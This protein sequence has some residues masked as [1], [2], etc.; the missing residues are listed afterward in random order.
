M[1]RGQYDRAAA[2]AKREAAEGKPAPKAAKAEKTAAAADA[3]VKRKYTR[4]AVVAGQ[5]VAAG[6]GPRIPR[7]APLV[8]GRLD[9]EVGDL[10]RLERL[11]NIRTQFGSGHSGGGAV[12]NKL[13]ALIGVEADKLMPADTKVAEVKAEKEPKTAKNG[14]IKA[15]APVDPATLPGFNP[16]PPP[17]LQQ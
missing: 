2:K 14:T 6:P 5:A 16:P 13:D 9:R 8:E 12:L 15:A 11:V 3:P 4:R 1:P 17:P 10:Y 7:N